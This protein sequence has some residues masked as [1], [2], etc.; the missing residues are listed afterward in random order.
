MANRLKIFR[1]QMAAFE[2]TVD[3]QQAI[4][5]GYYVPEPRRS[6]SEIISRR[7][8]LRPSSTHLLLGGIGSGKTTQLL[9]TRDRISRENDDIFA[10]YVDVSLYTD[11]SEICL[12]VLTAV[13][14]VV[15]SELIPDNLSE[16]IPD[17]N[18]EV[19]KNN[20][21]L[22]Q[23][24]AY[25]YSEKKFFDPLLQLPQINIGSPLS[26]RVTYTHH[27]GILTPKSNKQTRELLTSIN[28]INN[29]LKT[30]TKGI[31]LLL[32]GLDRLNDIK[33]FSQ[34]I[35]SDIQELSSIGIGVVLVGPL[36]ALYD[37]SSDGLE[38]AVNYFDYR[39]CYDVDNDSEAYQ[40]FENIIESRATQGFIEES[41]MKSLIYYSGGVLRD[42]I[43]LTQASIEEAYLSDGDIIQQPHV[44]T[45]V[46]SFGKARL[47]GLSESELETLEKNMTEDIFIPRTEEDIR[48][49]V[50]GRM[51]E[52]RYPERR[53]SVHPAIVP[54]L[55]FIKKAHKIHLALN[56]NE[57]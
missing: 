35:L 44:E 37:Q 39:S 11:I 57:E 51:L 54:V 9:V 7:I 48:L 31:V 30:K 34:L 22:I 42:L 47:L 41:A 56:N 16:L 38:Q 4:K 19:I 32:D 21:K 12:G 6:T 3:P 43:N 40:F 10:H 18:N 29:F 20:V 53:Y 26:P 52:Y 13:V 45:S 1:E 28:I 27:K 17:G 33:S 50:S 5:S 8:S 36:R 23:R 15:L 55:K 14:G 24:I 2:G 49:L 46:M 25:G